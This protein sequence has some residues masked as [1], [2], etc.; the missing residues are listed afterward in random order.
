VTFTQRWK[1]TA[2][3]TNV[4]SATTT[5]SYNFQCPTLVSVTAASPPSGSYGA[6]FTYNFQCI[7]GWYVW[8][9]VT[10]PVNTCTSNPLNITGTAIPAPSPIQD[11]ITATGSPGDSCTQVRNQTIYFALVSGGSA[12]NNNSV[13]S[14]A[15]TQTI[16]VTR[17]NSPP[18]TPHGT[19]TASVTLGGGASWTY[20]Y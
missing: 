20:T 9:D 13:C 7:N 16:T 6:N 12:T 1:H 5:V 8:E 4:D 14:I 18:A 15:N 3:D 19:V 10:E 17:T 11:R 2:C